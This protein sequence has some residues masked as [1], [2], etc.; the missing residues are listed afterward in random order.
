MLKHVRS[1]LG[2]F[3]ANEDGIK[4]QAILPVAWVGAVMMAAAVVVS[5]PDKAHA[6]YCWAAWGCCNCVSSCAEQC[7]ASY[8]GCHLYGSSGLYRCRCGSP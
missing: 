1:V 5:M 3:I 2:G 8:S 4:K 7:Y 6:D